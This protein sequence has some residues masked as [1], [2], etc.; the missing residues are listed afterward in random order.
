MKR[1]GFGERGLQ[2]EHDGEGLVRIHLVKG[3]KPYAAYGVESGHGIREECLPVL[4][5]AGVDPDR[6]TVVMFCN[7]SVWDAEKRT[8]RQNSP[9]YAGGNA[10]AGN[11]WQVDSPLLDAALLA[12]KEP[13]LQ[14]GQYGRISVGRYN[15]IFVGGVAH[16]LG[17][18]LGLP[19]NRERPDEGALWG[20]ALMG[21]GNRSYGEERRG[22]GKGSF[23]T[24]AHGLRLISH[25]LFS[26]TD[27]GLL[28]E[29]GAQ[30]KDFSITAS[31]KGFQLEGTVGGSPAVYAVVAY[32][33]PEGGGDYDATTASAVPD[34]S[35]RFVLDCRGL[36]AGKA[37]TLRLVAC[38]V[39]GLT[40]SAPPMG[41]TVDQDGN[42]DLSAMGARFFLAPCRIGYGFAGT[43]HRVMASGG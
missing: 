29:T 36:Q 34:D 17:H 32:L 4:R 9:Y 11:A 8:M 13:M 22:E 5:A 15:S 27:K 18:S 26:G 23:L 28:M 35:G 39:N 42:P 37:A 24:L 33:D 16:E 20:T 38:H 40:S 43:D 19:H 30:W 10:R 31:G 3:A 1:L 2:W 12:E 14:D 41:Y 6:N 7:M 21:S 25:P